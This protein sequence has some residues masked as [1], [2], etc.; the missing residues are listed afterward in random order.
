MMIA[1]CLLEGSTVTLLDAL[2]QG[3]LDSATVQPSI[4]STRR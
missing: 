3:M 2:V 1:S 4:F